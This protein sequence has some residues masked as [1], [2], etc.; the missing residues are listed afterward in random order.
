MGALDQKIG[1]TGL[2]NKKWSLRVKARMIT[3]SCPYGLPGIYIYTV[4]SYKRINEVPSNNKTF[5]GF[6]K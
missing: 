6:F 1:I 5:P 3:K 4:N 2:D